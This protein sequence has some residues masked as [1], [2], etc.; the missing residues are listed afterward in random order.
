MAKYEAADSC[1]GGAQ[2]PPRPGCDCGVCAEARHKGIPYSRT[3]PAL[4][5][6]EHNVLARADFAPDIACVQMGL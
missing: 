4:Y 2:P 3:G 6:P 5:L 1:S